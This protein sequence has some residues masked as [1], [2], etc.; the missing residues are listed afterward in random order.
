M[1]ISPASN[2]YRVLGVL[3]VFTLALV[4]VGLLVL[5]VFLLVRGPG[6]SAASASPTRISVAATQAVFVPT[7]TQGPPTA[8][9]APTEASTPTAPPA[10]SDTP[11]VSATTARVVTI[12]KPANVRTGPGLTY[13]VIGGLNP[14]QTAPVVGRDSS[15]Q[16][17][18]I[19]FDGAPQGTGWVSALVATYDGSVDD[20]PVIQAAAPPPPQATAVPPTATAPPPPAATNTPGVAGANGIQ[21]ISFSMEKTSGAVNE[22][23]W[24]DFSVVN[25]TGS[26]ITYGILAAHTDAGV[27]ADS[28]H[29]PLLPGKQLDWKDHINFPQAG[30]Y[31]VYLGICYSNHDACKTGGAPWT[32]LS[33]SIAVTIQ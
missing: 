7:T 22:S 32:R 18:A 15:A 26:D 11:A 30:A 19:S 29:E 33:N 14:G 17:F 21:T 20:L 24:F 8:T 13:L 25:T 9:L 5:A 12:G 2:R 27:T 16:W 23:M 3:G 6:I 4:G 10:P 1:T 31:Q 28:W